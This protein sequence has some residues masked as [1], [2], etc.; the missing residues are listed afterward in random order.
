MNKL[1]LKTLSQRI[2]TDHNQEKLKAHNLKIHQI[3][4]AKGKDDC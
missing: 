1:L 3:Q 4:S 2:L